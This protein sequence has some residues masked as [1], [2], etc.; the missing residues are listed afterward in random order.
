MEPT[1][2]GPS[3]YPGTPAFIVPSSQAP[4]HSRTAALRGEK[5]RRSPPR[6][7]WPREAA[8]LPITLCS[9]I[10]RR[11]GLP[12]QAARALVF[13]TIT[14]CPMGGRA[15]AHV[16]S[17]ARRGACFRLSVPHSVR[18]IHFCTRHPVFQPGIQPRHIKLH[19]SIHLANVYWVPTGGCLRVGRRKSPSLC[20]T[21]TLGDKRDKHV[22]MTQ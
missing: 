16:R 10:F 8:L 7:P 3:A 11:G 20:E 12:R 4:E 17:I 9:N 21:Y 6:R 15:R 1:A 5:T 2:L 14:L 22:D 19:S 13:T 18:C